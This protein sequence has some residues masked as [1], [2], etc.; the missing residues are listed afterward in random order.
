M[1]TAPNRRDFI[2]SIASACAGLAVF[3]MLG[4]TS[5]FAEPTEQEKAWEKLPDNEKAAI[6][7]KWEEYKKLSPSEQD[8]LKK[9]LERYNALTEEQKQLVSKA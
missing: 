1:S 2:K 4:A 5:A 8:E 6:E 7:K 9:G 3:A